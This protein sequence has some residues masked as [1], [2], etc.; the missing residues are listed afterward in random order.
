MS[1]L[2]HNELLPEHEVFQ[3]KIPTATKEAAERSEP[4][5]KQVEHGPELYQIR[6]GDVV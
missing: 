6:V 3:D 5:Q 4:K 2:Q 1:T